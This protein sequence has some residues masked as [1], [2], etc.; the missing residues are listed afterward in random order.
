MHAKTL[1]SNL[2]E[3]STESSADY[4]S[5]HLQR[6]L[7]FP[8]KQRLWTY[9]A[10]KA[11]SP[12]IWAE[13]GVFSGFSINHFAKLISNQEK[14]IFGFDSFEG[15]KEDWF[16]TD[17]PQGMFHLG[18]RLPQVLPN[19][20]LVPGWFDVTLPRFLEEQTNSFSLIHCDADTYESTCTI[21]S[22]LKERITSNTV[23]LF[24]EYLNYP[25]WQN[26]EFKAWQEFCSANFL[27][28]QYLGFSESAAAVKILP[29]T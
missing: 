17:A 29:E 7:L 8:E 19:V 20:R 21:L 1:Y 26:G 16:G 13:F 11:T 10:G 23:I 14:V 25:N 4:V 2:W 15:L 9:A 28:Y 18:G 6:A 27:K 22:L 12:G 3:R 5:N 24:D